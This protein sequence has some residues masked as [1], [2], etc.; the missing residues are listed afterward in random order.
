VA[1]ISG[2]QDKLSNLSTADILSVLEITENLEQ[3]VIQEAK[4]EETPGNSGNNNAVKE[5]NNAG[6]GQ[7]P[8]KKQ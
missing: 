2:I 5:G 1:I 7:N 4:K 8:T 3:K 6:K